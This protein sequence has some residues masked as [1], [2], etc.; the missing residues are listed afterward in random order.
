M[1][2][3]AP[4]NRYSLPLKHAQSCTGVGSRTIS[5]ENPSFSPACSVSRSPCTALR[6]QRPFGDWR[7]GKADVIRSWEP[8]NKRVSSRVL[9]G[10]LNG[11]IGV[12]KSILAEMT[13]HTNMSLAYSYQ[14]ITWSTGA[15][16]G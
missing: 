14:P 8:L 15:T 7:L 9:N 2:G 6:Y 1:R 5:A 16:L 13:D 4:S 3:L 10:A 12:I 11:N